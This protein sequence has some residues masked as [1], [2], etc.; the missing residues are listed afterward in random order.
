[1]K[2]VIYPIRKL[3]QADYN[4]RKINYQQLSALKDSIREFGLV[5]PVIVNVNP[6]RKNVI[7][8]GHQRVKAAREL[9][10]EEVPCVELNLTLEKEREL[11]I[12]L[13]KNT[14][15]W[16]FDVLLDQFEETELLGYGF[17]PSEL[18]L[19]DEDGF[20]K[21]GGRG[22]DGIAKEDIILTF[23]I[24]F[25]TEDQLAKWTSFIHKLD[26]LYPGA[27]SIASKIVEF[28]EDN[29]GL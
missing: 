5:D 12:R 19:E 20:G 18:A 10:L 8:G 27:G 7:I 25:D 11:N 4:P 22:E 13:N 1:M 6:E 26:T 16:D 24:I 2:T 9:G 21:G 29:N 14:G 28:V 23:E 17:E 15:E 3:I